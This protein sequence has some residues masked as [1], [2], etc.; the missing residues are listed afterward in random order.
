MGTGAGGLHAPAGH[1]REH[2]GVVP[3]RH[4][5][6]RHHGRVRCTALP[7]TTPS[8]CSH[9]GCLHRPSICRYFT[10]LLEFKDITECPGPILYWDQGHEHVFGDPTAAPDWDAVWHSSMHLPLPLLSVSVVIRD[11]LAAH[12]LRDAPVVP[13]AIDC[14]AFRPSPTPTRSKRGRGVAAGSPP[15][16]GGG[17][18]HSTLGPERFQPLSDGG[19]KR[20]LL[21][22]NPGLKLKNFKAALDAL[23]IVQ[24]DLQAQGHP[25]ISVTWICQV[26]PALTGVAFP[27]SFAVNPPQE[28]LP[29][30][31]A[32][33][34]DVFLFTSVY[35]AW[36]MPVLEAMASGV[37]VVAARCHGVDTFAFHDHNALLADPYDCAGLAAAVTRVLSSP[38]LAGRLA[39]QGRAMAEALTWDNS[40]AALEGALYQVSHFL[41]PPGVGGE[42][43]KLFKAVVA[44]NA[45]V[46]AEGGEPARR[47]HL[48]SAAA[49]RGL[50]AERLAARLSLL[51]ALKWY[52]V[53]VNA[54]SGMWPFD[55]ATLQAAPAQEAL[56]GGG[57]L[58]VGGV[59]V[60]PPQAER[61]APWG[62]K[63]ATHPL[64]P[65]FAFVADGVAVRCIRKGGRAPPPSLPRDS[66][67]AM[68]VPKAKAYAAA[69][70]LC[71]SHVCGSSEGA[72]SPDTAASEPRRRS[73]RLRQRDSA[74]AAQA[75][76]EPPPHI[77]AA[78]PP[79]RTG[80]P[81]HAPR[82]PVA[83]HAS[84]QAAATALQ[85]CRSLADLGVDAN[86]AALVAAWRLDGAARAGTVPS[87]QPGAGGGSTD[88]FPATVL[89]AIARRPT[90]QQLGSLLTQHQ[91]QQRNVARAAQQSHA[92]GSA[93]WTRGVAAVTGTGPGQASSG[94][95]TATPTPL[96]SGP[97]T[98]QRTDA[99]QALL[100]RIQ[101]AARVTPTP[102]GRPG[103]A[104]WSS[105]PSLPTGPVPVLPGTAAMPA[106]QGGYLR[107]PTS[108]SAVPMPGGGAFPPTAMAALGDLLREEPATAALLGQLERLPAQGPS[109][110]R[111]DGVVQ[112]CPYTATYTHVA[113]H[114]A[115]LPVTVLMPA[116]PNE[117]TALPAARLAWGTGQSGLASP[118]VSWGGGAAT[119][120]PPTPG[121]PDAVLSRSRPPPSTG[122][123]AE[124]E[125]LWRTLPD[126]TTDGLA[127]GGGGRS[128]Y[129]GS[130]APLAGAFSAGDRVPGHHN[131]FADSQLSGFSLGASG[132]SLLGG[133]SPSSSG[134]DAPAPSHPGSPAGDESPSKGKL[135]V[136]DL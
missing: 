28:H 135:S 31:Y 71:E 132:V 96:A 4:T 27:V 25:G 91:Q 57:A 85:A 72:G 111:L 124:D 79:A 67:L 33:G 40:M 116:D 98:P 8:P 51:Q 21:V 2:D 120:P 122:T 54:S 62:L 75:A 44:H 117:V 125:A 52:V 90:L 16:Q 78:E 66:P 34:H 133:Q 10:Q 5:H 113:G 93:G 19:L 76:W 65:P 18:G 112:G 70:A 46:D 88:G 103:G 55:A 128:V 49:L 29:T 56:Q 59:A 61:G 92:A 118:G 64:S 95:S 47:V 50:Y 48:P 53:D 13:N 99:G 80:S 106:S 119:A 82:E 42:D 9:T 94:G 23:N 41:G 77:R 136:A 20:V 7:P 100:A 101:A 130:T 87:L 74:A 134:A 15:R 6:R 114:A 83:A 60:H 58:Q 84:P 68:A 121:T 97:T 73:K 35:E 108:P 131:G 12:Y 110:L 105:W 32:S 63:G 1:A 129:R 24:R 107:T 69:V 126:G 17:E 102:T 86:V 11:V 104:G 36:G 30:L 22:G 26:Q 43:S 3:G 14:S 109:G 123:V 38:E 39:T 37:P 81:V 115:A 89:L 45:R 127:S